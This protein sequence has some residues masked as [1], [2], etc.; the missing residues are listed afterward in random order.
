MSNG[1][2]MVRNRRH[3]RPTGESDIPKSPN[4]HMVVH[5][6]YGIVIRHLEIHELSYSYM[7]YFIV[8]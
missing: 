2:T 3:L 8:S 4:H 1:G 5:A 7:Y 6:L